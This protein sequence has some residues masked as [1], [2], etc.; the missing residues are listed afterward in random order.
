MVSWGGVSL[1][2][3]L[4][5]GRFWIRARLIKSLRWDDAAHLLG[6][7]FLLAQVS[8]V[9]WM[10][11]TIHARFELLDHH[12]QLRLFL[13]LD[14]AA[15]ILSWSCL[16]A[17]KVA[18]LLLYHQIFRVSETF[19]W[20]WW[21]TSVVTFVTFWILIIGTLTKCGDAADLTNLC[22]FP[23]TSDADYMT[24]MVQRSAANPLR[25][26]TRLLWYIT[27]VC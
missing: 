27:A 12:Q 2:I 23:T 22:R 11:S 15:I 24:D 6:L 1:A 21:I 4:S 16:Y 25:S 5:L 18:F 7:L 14:V 19:M 3:L 9:S 17:I 26:A 20:A 10:Q 8:M 13:R